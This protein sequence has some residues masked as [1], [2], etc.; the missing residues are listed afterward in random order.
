MSSPMEPELTEGQRGSGRWLVINRP[1][2]RN[3]LSPAVLLMMRDALSR[4]ER[5]PEVRSI[6][7]TGAGD[8]AFCA[9]ADLGSAASA[10]DGLLAAHEV[11]RE[12]GGLLPDLWRLGNAGVARVHGSPLGGGPGPSWR[13]GL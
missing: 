2:Q 4:A 7:I 5:D 3:S 12:Y 11:R 10:G 1:A 6:C 8:K 13:P 9:G